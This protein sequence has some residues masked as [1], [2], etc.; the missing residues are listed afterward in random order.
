MRGRGHDRSSAARSTRAATSPTFE[1]L[2]GFSGENILY[3]GDHIY[4]DILKSK[5]TSLWRTCMIVQEIEDEI[6]YTDAR[7]D[8][9]AELS[10][11]RAASAR[12]STTRSTTARRC[13]TRSS[14]GWSARTLE[15]RGARRSWRRSASARRPSWTSCAARCKRGD[16]DRRHARAGRRGGL[17]PVLGPAVQGR[18][19]EQPLRRAGGAVRVHLHEPG[20]ELPALLADAVLPLAARPDAA[21][22]GRRAVRE[23]CHP[24]GG[25]GPAKAASTHESL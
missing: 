1:K 15:R 23:S 18:K 16:R 2:T 20:L 11:D 22:A 25:E 6:D 19:R 17:Q 12:G 10:R 7:K 24:L 13:S 14:G 3:V 21:R 9:I 4:G 5:K 8:E